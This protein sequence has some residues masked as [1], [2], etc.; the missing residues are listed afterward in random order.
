MA[1]D[2]TRLAAATEAKGCTACDLYR[3]A[4]QTVF[5]AGDPRADL[6]LVGEQPGDREDRTGEPFVGPAGRVLDDAL[7]QADIAR[8][9]VY[10]TNAVK[11]FKWKPRGKRRIHQ[12]PNRAEI[13]AC[14]PWLETEL[15]V[16]D[17]AV[18]IVLGA[19]A[20][21]RCSARASASARRASRCSRGT[22]NT[23]AHRE[24]VVAVARQAAPEFDIADDLDVVELDH[25]CG[26]EELR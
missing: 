9:H 3:N 26:H 6:M 4:T 2:S 10:V 11:H 5:G 14:R 25:G 19:I 20:G 1:P 8:E 24:A 21:K 22:V 23:A 16:V 15:E 18:V 12:K 17:P 7:L 13:L